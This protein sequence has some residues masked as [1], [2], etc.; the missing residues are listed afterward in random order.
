MPSYKPLQKLAPHNPS[1]KMPPSHSRPYST[2]DAIPRLSS[3]TQKFSNK[4][5]VQNSRNKQPFELKKDPRD[6]IINTYQPLYQS[7]VNFSNFNRN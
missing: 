5:I 4:E 7:K 3:S 1:E 2:Q 6:K